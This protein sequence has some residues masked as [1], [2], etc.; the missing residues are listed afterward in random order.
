MGIV[1]VLVIALFVAFS[2]PSS[3]I[4]HTD[5]TGFAQGKQSPSHAPVQARV[6]L[7]EAREVR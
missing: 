6:Y 5:V 2:H 3:K 4:H 7:L 1:A